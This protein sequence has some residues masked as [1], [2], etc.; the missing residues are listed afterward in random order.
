MSDVDMTYALGLHKDVA[1]ETR[2][3]KGALSY[4]GVVSQTPVS[5]YRTW[6]MQKVRVCYWMTTALK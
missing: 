6:S 5:Y 3:I 2:D 4:L 1:K